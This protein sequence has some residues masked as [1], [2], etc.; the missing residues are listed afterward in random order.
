MQTSAGLQ[1]GSINFQTT[2][3]AYDRFMGRYSSPLAEAFLAT[4]DLAIGR[5]ALDAG[6]GPGA[7]TSAL[8]AK[9]GASAV[10]A[11]DPSEP[12]VAECR[13]RHPRVDVRLGRAEQI[14]FDDAQFDFVFAQLVLHFVSDPSLALRE[15]QRV[16]RSGSLIAATV[17]EFA[18]G[19]E[20]L[21]LFWDA[22]LS[23]D[24][25]TPD[26]ARTLRFGREGELETLFLEAGLEGVTETALRVETSYTDYDELWAGFQAG[27]GPAGAY[28]VTLSDAQQAAVRTGMY[29]RL[30]SPTGPFTLSATA[31][32]TRG[33]VR[34]P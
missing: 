32:C 28:C 31:R 3:A 14:P 6:C 23:I 19:M 21:R 20:M 24:P 26:E 5:S 27:I 18:N 34:T 12:F 2:G 4:S 10:A 9:L 29:E 16:A 1:D 8:V 17:W 25:A 33:L 15:M 13:A 7:L 22:A 30:G 11:F